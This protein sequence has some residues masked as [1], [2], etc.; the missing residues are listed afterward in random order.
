MA[1]LPE[2]LSDQAIA[3]PPQQVPHEGAKER[4]IRG[5]GAIGIATGLLVQLN[6]KGPVLFA[7]KAPALPDQAQHSLWGC[8]MAGE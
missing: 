6:D 4:D 8:A 1:Q 5:P 2:A 7:L 3:T